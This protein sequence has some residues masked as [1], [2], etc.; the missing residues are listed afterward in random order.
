MSM[1][2]KLL[3]LANYNLIVIISA[4]SVFLTVY[5]LIMALSKQKES[6]EE[7]LQRFTALRNPHPTSSSKMDLKFLLSKLGGLTPKR[8]REKI[9]QEL[10]R[11]DIPLKGGEFLVLQGFLALLFYLAGILITRN[12]LFSLLFLFTGS[13]IPHIWLKTSQKR[14]RKQFNNQLA[15]S[16]LILANSLRAGFS[17]LQA[18]EMVSQEMPNPISSEFKLT[19]KE[20]T[21]GTSTETALLHLAERVDS[22][23]LDLLVTAVLIQRQVGGNLA[24]ILMNIHATIQDRIRIQLEIKS[25][26]AQGRMSGY[27]ISALPFGIAAILTALNP[28]YLKILITEPLGLIMIGAGLVAQVIGFIII[29]KIITIEA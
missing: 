3:A 23:D 20:M 9:D 12:I 18:M 16:L 29:R 27:I 6:L 15:D 8:W 14:K 4:A 17:L 5:L 24:E 1:L 11:G 28:S 19:L 7:K 22:E 26:T 2:Y 25:L 13:I 21:Y 10:M